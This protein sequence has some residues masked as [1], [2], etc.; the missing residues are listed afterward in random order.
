MENKIEW[1]HSGRE[2]LRLTF[3]KEGEKLTLTELKVVGCLS[4]L[5]LSQEMKQK[6]TGPIQDLKAPDGQDH[7]SLIWQEVVA[8][9]KDQWTPPEIPEELCHC[10]KVSQLK[11]DHSIV[12]GAHDIETIRKRT[13]ANTGC[14]TC[15]VSIESLIDNRLKSS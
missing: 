7:A 6:L 1:I 5:K 14:G 4:F 10:R 11:V 2:S 9:I 15:K 8:K 12:Y 13:S 3:N